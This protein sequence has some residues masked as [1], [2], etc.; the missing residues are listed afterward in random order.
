MHRLLTTLLQMVTPVHQTLVKN[1]MTHP[2]HMSNLV[3]HHPHRTK[4]YQIIVRLVLLQLEKTLIVTS[5]RKDPSSISNASQAKHEVPL[6]T[7]VQ[8]S[9]TDSNHAKAICRQFILQHYQ[10]IFGIKL[11]FFSI[12]VDTSRHP[13]QLLKLFSN[14][15]FHWVKEA[16]TIIL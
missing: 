11:R 4:L 8:V 2:E 6:F 13:L 10:N 14:F 1:T 7:R 15:Y 12:G 9:H 16:L 5:K 3:T